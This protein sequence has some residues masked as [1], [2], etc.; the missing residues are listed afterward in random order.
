MQFP[1][2]KRFTDKPPDSIPPPGAYDVPVHSP[3]PTY[4]RAAMTDRASRFP[5][6]LSDHNKPDTFGLYAD[7]PL[8]TD[9]ENARPRVRTTSSSLNPADRERHKAQL[10]DLR[11]RMTA[12]HDKET[13]KL[14]AK[15]DKLDE[16]RQEH[17][18]EREELYKEADRLKSENRHLTSKLSRSTALQEKYE[19]TLPSLQAKLSTLTTQHAASSAKKDADLSQLRI[20]LSRAEADTDEARAQARAWEDRARLEQRARDDQALA[21][22]ELA[23]RLRDDARIARADDLYAERRRCAALERRIADRDAI[24]ASVAAHAH[25]LEEQLALAT[26]ERLEAEWREWRLRDAWREDRALLVGPGRDEKEWRQRARADGREMDGLRDDVALGERERADEREWDAVRAEWERR[27]DKAAREDKKR[28]ERDL[29]VV[30]GELDLAVNDEIPRLEALLAA[31]EASLSTA[32]SDLSNATAQ[33]AQLEADLVDLET[34]RQDDAERFEGELEEQ[35]RLVADARREAERERVEKRRVV[36]ILAQTRAS[37][38][39][40]KDEV[41]SLV[42]QVAQLDPLVAITADLEHKVD[43]LERLCALSEAEARDLVAHNSEL[44]GHA[45]SGQKIRHVAMIREELADTRRKHAATQSQLSTATTRIKALELELDLYR[46]VG[47]T[48]TPSSVGTMSAAPGGRTRVARP[49]MADVLDASAAAPV[50]RAAPRP[51]ASAPAAAS[52]ATP[53]PAPVAA[54]ASAP[55][56]RL[57]VV[58]ARDSLAAPPFTTTSSSS[59]TPTVQFARSTSALPAHPH[60]PASAWSVAPDEPLLPAGLARSAGPGPASKA[61]AAVPVRSAMAGGRTRRKSTSVKMQGTM[62]VSEL[63]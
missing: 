46:P 61:G 14:R 13:A 4:K 5:D 2:A 11:A 42:Q 62:S 36:G 45:N 19:A 35:R 25:A 26:A 57:V 20:T 49:M 31:S 40:L 6:P 34:R 24:L 41:D 56:P 60:E 22:G 23:A 29:E 37:E 7:D 30:E 32:R 63:F 1:K 8:A 18:K 58:P 17:R 16:A 43:H 51:R 59:S 28:L 21:A 38:G 47:V 12:A 48:A 3:Q 39:A 33:L 55:P 15:L 54:A 50:V 9:K 27:R 44:A 53:T 10:E 52:D